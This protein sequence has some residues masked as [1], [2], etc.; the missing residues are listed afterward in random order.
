[1]S[2]GWAGGR[3]ANGPLAK[4]GGWLAAPVSSVGGGPGVAR[5]GCAEF[6][7]STPRPPR[8]RVTSPSLSRMKRL[9]V[10]GFGCF[11]LEVG[12]SWS[13]NRGVAVS[14]GLGGG[15]ENRFQLPVSLHLEHP[16]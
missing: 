2:T 4:G 7:C 1:M 8:T 3:A 5:A 10:D 12:K 11:V 9:E 15:L 6:R 14:M 16:R 13:G